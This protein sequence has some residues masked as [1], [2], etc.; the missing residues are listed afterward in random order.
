MTK[1]KH[2]I[3]AALIAA[4][5]TVTAQAGQ[6]TAKVTPTPTTTPESQLTGSLDVSVASDYIYHGQKIDSNP[7]VVPQLNLALPLT[8]NTTLEASVQQV[9]GTRGDAWYRTQY[10]VGVALKAGSFTLTPGFEF[11]SSPSNSFKDSKAVTARLAFD[12]SGLGLLP[13]ALNPY[14]SVLNRVDSGRGSSW[15][16]GVAPSKSFGVLTVSAPVAFGA[17][18]GGYYTSEKD[19]VHYAYASAGLAATYKVTERLSLN[20]S[21]VGYTTD[22]RVGNGKGSNFV[23]TRA[24][25]SVSF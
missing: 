25:V 24:G 12:D 8:K 18:A 15:E 11:A 16:A 2:T 21:A 22:D 1:T 5:F 14:V 7:V 23:T 3:V 13:V 6:S 20:A 19:S 9:L 10:N 17:G 4:A